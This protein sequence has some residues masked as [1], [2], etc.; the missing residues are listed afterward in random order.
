MEYQNK[1]DIGAATLTPDNMNTVFMKFLIF[2][3]PL[4]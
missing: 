1:A 2:F 4:Q 3:N